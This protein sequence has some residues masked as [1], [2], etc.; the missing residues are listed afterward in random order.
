MTKQINGA[1]KRPTSFDVARLAGVSQATVSRVY[2]DKWDGK[3][4]QETRERVLQASEKLGYSKNKIAKG[5]SV[6]RTGIVGIIKSREFNLFYDKIISY[7][8]DMLSEVGINVMVFNSQV[9]SDINEVLMSASSYQLDGIVLTSASLTHQFSSRWFALGTP[10]VLINSKA[11]NANCNRVYSDNRGGTAMLARFLYRNGYRRYAFVS[12]AR[13]I[14]QN[15]LERQEGFFTQM[16]QYPDVGP[17]QIVDGDYTY[18]SGVEAADILLT[19]PQKPELIFCANDYMALGVIDGARY[20]HGL[21]VPDDISVAGFDDSYATGQ[22]GYS[23]TSLQQQPKLLAKTAVDLLVRRI[24][25]G[26]TGVETICIP[27][28]LVIR[29]SVRITVPESVAEFE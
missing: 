20:R 24:Q 23:L 12:S 2:N 22:L 16:K 28:K 9:S 10:T 18:Q 15:H 25:D 26:E 14:Y 3:I 21:S 4:S 1:A 11:E 27:Q 17:I 8:I 5:L 13:S 7:L 29:S 6:R 19:Q